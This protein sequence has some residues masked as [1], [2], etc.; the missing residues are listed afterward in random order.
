MRRDPGDENAPGAELDEEEHIQRLQPDRLDREEVAGDDRGACARRNCVQVGL[1]R[2]GAGPRP[3]RRSRVR[4]VVAPTRMPSLRSSP[5]ILTQPQR[6][7][8][9]AI[10]M[11]RSAA[12]AS[13]GGLPGLRSLR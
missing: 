12:S 11:T 1:E 13:I 6:G 10:R 4:I 9:L 5:A 3:C 7:F 2:L 8:S